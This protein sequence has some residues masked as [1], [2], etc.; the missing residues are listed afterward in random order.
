M[1]H[2][3][4]GKSQEIMKLAVHNPATSFKLGS[5]ALLLAIESL[6]TGGLN[7]RKNENKVSIE[8]MELRT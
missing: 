5:P 7:E 1:E 3:L 4:G 8:S 6:L 2:R